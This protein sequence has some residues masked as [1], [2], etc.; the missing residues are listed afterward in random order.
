MERPDGKDPG[1]WRQNGTAEGGGAL[2]TPVEQV[3]QPAM[4]QGETLLSRLTVLSE[5]VSNNKLAGIHTRVCPGLFAELK[6]WGIVASVISLY[7]GQR[8]KRS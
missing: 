5:R 3:V 7:S 4:E 1:R 6:T 8:I 2:V